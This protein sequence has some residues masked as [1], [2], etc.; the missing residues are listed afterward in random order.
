MRN[1]LRFLLVLVLA[2]L[3]LQAPAAAAGKPEFQ[4][5]H[6]EGGPF[7]EESVS[8]ECGFDV[9][10]SFTSDLIIRTF[11]D[12]SQTAEVV[13]A[14]FRVTLEANGNTVT[15]QEAGSG[16]IKVAPDGT[17]TQAFSGRF[18]E[19]RYAGRLVLNITPGSED[20]GEVIVEPKRFDVEQLCARLAA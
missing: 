17:V 18:F 10:A 2:A 15:F 12:G 9:V 4:R 6:F 5:L 13:T 7:L 1:F 3:C 16:V 14:R 20:E 19:A 8:E 11:P